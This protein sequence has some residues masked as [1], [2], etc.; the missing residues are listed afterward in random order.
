MLI[1]CNYCILPTDHCSLVVRMAHKI[2]DSV[3]TLLSHVLCILPVCLYSPPAGPRDQVQTVR[4][5]GPS[6]SPPPSVTPRRPLVARPFPRD[7]PGPRPPD[8]PPL[9][10][11]HAAL[12]GS[13][14]NGDKEQ[15]KRLRL[16]C[17]PDSR[18]SPPLLSLMSFSRLSPLA[19]SCHHSCLPLSAVQKKLL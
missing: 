14:W 15:C 12:Q 2:T 11:C 5:S 17:Q 4:T 13:R 19:L 3:W 1:K 6:F 18:V 9:P 8:Q 16:E 10:R 7:L